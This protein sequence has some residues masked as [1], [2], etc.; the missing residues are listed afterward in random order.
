LLKVEAHR[1][2]PEHAEPLQALMQRAFSIVPEDARPKDT[3]AFLTHM[4]GQANPA[5]SAMLSI[6][7]DDD[8]WVGSAS[9]TA[10][11]FRRSDGK[12]VTGYQVGYFVVD[13]SVQRQGMGKKLIQSLT[14]ALR[15]LP[16]SFIYTYPNARS[17]AVFD[18]LQY[19]R[20]KSV[21][22]R[23]LLPHPSMFTGASRGQ[24]N[25]GNG[26]KADLEFV[27]SQSLLQ[28]LENIRVDD[29]KKAGFVRDVAYFKWRFLGPDADR[30]YHFVY[31]RA[32][33]S[34][35]VLALARHGFHGIK[36]AVLVDALPEL[37]AE[38]Y[39]LITRA[40][41]AAGW[42]NQA[43]FVYLNTSIGSGLAFQAS[44]GGVDVPDRFN[45]RPVRLL[46]EPQTS[47]IKPEEL[48]DSL[49]MTADWMGF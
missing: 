10:M 1:F 33:G 40:A 16:D 44:T 28:R 4:L 43:P 13:S 30:R 11:R 36:F 26:I 17:I 47:T 34:D 45:P 42:K 27:D 15:Q 18:R 25:L 24:L 29:G 35:T 6:A 9:G 12:I 20:L 21:S 23:I 31:V 48:S 39:S 46:M 7:S 14:E 2:E 22:T 19:Q 32:N 8:R 41:Q 38:R 49:I 3:P 37:T 5:G